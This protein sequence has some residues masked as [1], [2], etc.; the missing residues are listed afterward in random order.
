MGANGYEEIKKHPFFKDIDWKLAEKRGLQPATREYCEN[1][2]DSDDEIAMFTNVNRCITQERFTDVDYSE[3]G[4]R[5]N[6]LNDF[7]FVRVQ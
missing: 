3:T 7:S 5:T 6:R 4:I 1:G 2:E